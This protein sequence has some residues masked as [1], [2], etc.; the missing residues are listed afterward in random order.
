[1]EPSNESSPFG[2]LS[3]QAWVGAQLQPGFLAIDGFARGARAIAKETTPVSARL[4]KLAAMEDDLRRCFHGEPTPDFVDLHAAM[5]EYELPF[6]PFQT[7]LGAFRAELTTTSYTTF[8]QLML[9][10]EA[11]ANPIGQLVLLVYGERDPALHRFSDALCT[12]LR[13]TAALRDVTVDLARGHCTTP[14]ED[15][16]HFGVEQAALATDS[17]IPQVRELMRFQATRARS[18]LQRGTPL[19]RQVGTDLTHPLTKRVQRGMATLDA[20]A[21]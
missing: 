11:A 4:E 18:I 7:M 13:L 6:V 19:L 15:L 10:C 8:S 9:H 1:M 14:Q 17:T 5:Q 3:S 21:T 16:I 12:G 2:P 20:I